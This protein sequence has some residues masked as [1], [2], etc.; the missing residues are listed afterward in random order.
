VL[1]FLS[2]AHD[3]DDR[4]EKGYIQQQYHQLLW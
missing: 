1:T 2:V 3:K 4:Y